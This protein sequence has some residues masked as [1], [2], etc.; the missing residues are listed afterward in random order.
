MQSITV[1]ESEAGRRI[2]KYLMKYLDAA[3]KS[4]IYKAFRKKNIKLCGK[5][6]AGD[7]LLKKGDLIELFFS[8]E[9]LRSL[10]KL[11]TEKS[12]FS[13]ENAASNTNELSG[14]SRMAETLTGRSGTLTGMSWMST[15]IS[16][17]SR[18]SDA[19]GIRR[20][21]RGN[22]KELSRYCGIVYEDS[23][24]IIADKRFG[25]LSQKAERNDYSLND[26]LLDY[27]GGQEKGAAF[28][29]SVVNRIDR[30]T[31][32]IVCFARTYGAAKELSRVFKTRD[33][34]K[35]YI[36]AVIGHIEGTGHDRAWLRKSAKT[37]KVTIYTD[38]QQDAEYIETAYRP[39]NEAEAA[40][41]GIESRH[42]YGNVCGTD[43]TLLKVELITGKSHQ[44]RAHLSHIGYAILG[45]PKYGNAA[46]NKQLSMKYGINGQ[47]L[48][49]W[50]LIMPEELNALLNALS[51]RSFKTKLPEGFKRLIG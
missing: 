9:T 38:K 28:V 39:I 45:D 5:R 47:L 6:A 19:S 10:R 15:G 3:P 42:A 17:V 37:N 49:A 8:D 31:T 7:E 41:L 35:Y 34:R 40:E 1:P 12:T 26:A 50:E 14:T 18:V 22:L 23:N 11:S 29:P 25:I 32:G 21:H 30:N 46:L 51:G 16:A 44:I 33:I 24:I 48:H 2:D 13:K 27:C 4:F 36:A 43:Y 20:V